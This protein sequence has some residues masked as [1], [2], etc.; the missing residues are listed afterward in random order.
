MEE[1]VINQQLLKSGVAGSV[2]I[3]TCYG[4]DRK[5]FWVRFPARQNT[6]FSRLPA[7]PIRPI[8]EVPGEAA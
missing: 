4:L 8:H 6:F 7:E 3:A 2:D 5:G 1:L